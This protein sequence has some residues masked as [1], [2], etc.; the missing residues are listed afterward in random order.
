MLIGLFIATALAGFAFGFNTRMQG[1]LSRSVADPVLT[2]ILLGFWIAVFVVGTWKHG[3]L[4]IPVGL[5]ASAIGQ[6]A[7]SAL[8]RRKGLPG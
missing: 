2:A 6:S 8:R 3:L 5:I 1:R 7:G 4:A